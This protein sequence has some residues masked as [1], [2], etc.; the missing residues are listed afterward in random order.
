MAATKPA[1][2]IVPQAKAM[3]AVIPSMHV[4]P[5]KIAIPPISKPFQS[6]PVGAATFKAPP[7]W[8]IRANEA[9]SQQSA[10]MLQIN[11][12]MPVGCQVRPWSLIPA[13]AWADE[14]GSFMAIACELFPGSLENTMVLPISVSS[15]A[16]LK[17]PQH[18]GKIAPHLEA[19]AHRKI[20]ALRAAFACE[21]ERVGKALARGNLAALDN[22][23]ERRS[24]YKADVINIAHALGVL[25]FG[26]DAWTTHRR[27]FAATLGWPQ[28]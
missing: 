6:T 7:S 22:R 19:E 9:A 13:S 26:I 17:L 27:I 4:A 11:R 18:P 20:G 8:Q 23:E 14:A 16:T 25:A 24:K 15:A 2:S 3:P 10:L 5:I 28:P 1:I 21:H 12:Q